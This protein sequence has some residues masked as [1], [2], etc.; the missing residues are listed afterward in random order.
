L[1]LA[2]ARILESLPMGLAILDKDLRYTYVNGEA[3]RFAQMPREQL[4]GKHAFDLFPELREGPF[5]AAM[6]HTL[7]T[8]EVSHVDLAYAPH[9]TWYELVIHPYE[10]GGVQ[11]FFMDAKVR[12]RQEHELAELREARDTTR[13]LYETILGA[14]PDFV[15]VWGKDYKFRYANPAL[16]ELYGVTA[17]QCIGKGFRDVGYPEW[18]ARMHEREIDE[19]VRTKRP[20]RGNIPFR[21]KGGGGI[22]DYIFVPVFGP[23]G[24]VEA[25]AGTTRDVT[26][27]DRANQALKEADRRKDEFLATLA[28]ELRNP[29]APLRNGL[30]LL[31]VDAD[32]ASQEH[33]L[34]IM[35]RQLGQMVHLVDDL[36]DLSRISRGVVE[37]RNERT[38]LQELVEM[39][40][41][42]ARTYIQAQGHTLA[43]E[44]PKEEVPME[45]D[46]TRLVQI[47]GNLLNNA[48]K[49]TDAG[50]HVSLRAAV[51]GEEVVLE[52]SDNG[53]GIEEKDRQRVFDM[54]TRV[55]GKDSSIRNSGLGIGLHI[56]KRLV[57]MHGGRIAVASGG[58]GKGTTFTVHLPSR[59][60]EQAAAES[61]S[62]KAASSARRILVVDDNVDAAFMLSVALK[63]KGHHVHATHGAREAIDMVDT[64]RPEFI[65]MDIGMPEMD[66]YEACLQ[67]RNRPGL[68]GTRIIALTGWGQAEDRRKSTSAG[69][70]A[71]LVKPV[72]IRDIEAILADADR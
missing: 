29:L 72:T 1:D 2:H 61:R 4:L 59:P 70:D 25:V 35:E 56:V 60:S 53:I 51:E 38:T 42:S 62:P 36:M 8:G 27:L 58:L 40:L 47:L 67:L 37:L 22:Y 12:V 65:F 23:D 18:H 32:P 3:E 45:G 6:E 14:T 71:H 28:H 9:D 68:S 66:G 17:E 64:F 41:E 39:T 21:G 46:L 24:E 11:I 55:P 19:V 49:Y 13:R 16:L 7:R 30:E 10:G 34:G 26:D 48:A 52:I 31:M 20:L 57:E 50:G 15:Y 43:V 44:L 5:M 33:V 69:F 54:F 63:N